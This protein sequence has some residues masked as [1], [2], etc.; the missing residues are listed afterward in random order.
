MH[1]ADVRT[2]AKACSK[3]KVQ[4][5]ACNLRVP[6]SPSGPHFAGRATSVFQMA[7]GRRD[8][9]PLMAVASLVALSTPAACLPKY[10]T[11]IVTVKE[12]VGLA[13]TGS[14]WVWLLTGSLHPR[15]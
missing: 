10:D 6:A 15:P 7:K 8:C 1:L 9:W 12:K 13:G 14:V 2:P 11:V 3:A 5:A 4:R